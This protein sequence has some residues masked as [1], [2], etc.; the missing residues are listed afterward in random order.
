VG[1]FAGTIKT[2]P[3]FNLSDQF[4]IFSECEIFINKNPSLDDYP[5]S[6]ENREVFYNGTYIITNF[7][8][9][10][11]SREAYSEFSVYKIGYPKKGA[12]YSFSESRVEG[13]EGQQDLEGYTPPPWVDDPYGTPSPPSRPYP[14]PTW[15]EDA[16][17]GPDDY[18]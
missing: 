7:K 1:G 15:E 13:S 17:C 3:Y 4:V 6:R 11:T 2:V 16:S 10:I 12:S 8:H 14:P 18:G 5:P 9:V